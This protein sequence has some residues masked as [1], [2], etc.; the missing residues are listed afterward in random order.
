[1]SDNKDIHVVEEINEARTCASE[2][3]GY[4]DW[5]MLARWLKVLFRI[6]GF[7]MFTTQRVIGL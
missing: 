2:W 3:G 4:D 1:M 5:I 7:C 6:D